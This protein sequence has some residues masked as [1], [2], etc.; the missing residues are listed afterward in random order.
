MN[1]ARQ[2]SVQ[3]QVPFATVKSHCKNYF[4]LNRITPNSFTHADFSLLAGSRVDRQPLQFRVISG[5]AASDD[6]QCFTVE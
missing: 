1:R 5:C 6:T 3:T 2:Y 4:V